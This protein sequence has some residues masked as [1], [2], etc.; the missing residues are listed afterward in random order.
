MS[1]SRLEK[2]GEQAT[3][4]MRVATRLTG[5]SADTIRKWEQR[6]AAVEPHRTDG[7]TRKFSSLDIHRLS[8]L[9]E[10]TLRGHHIMDVA[11]L[12]N[13]RLEA[14]LA[15]LD[16]ESGTAADG[17]TDADRSYARVRSDYLEAIERFDVRRAADLLSRAAMLL[18]AEDLALQVVRP[19]LL[20][21]G[22]RWHRREVSIAHEHL[23]SAQMRGLLTSVLNWSTPQ[24]G[25]PKIVV[26]TPA[27]HLHEFGTLVG[28]ILAASRGLEPIYL[29]PNLPEEEILRAVETTHAHLL[30]LSV[31]R[32]LGSDE[33]LA[34]SQSLRRM[35]SQVTTWIGVPSSDWFD[36]SGSDARL[37]ESY[38]QLD[39]AL[40]QVAAA[41]TR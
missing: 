28:A 14:L 3:Y 11:A 8:L 1:S 30:L 38:E 21:V 40:T 25:A 6:Y 33:R 24:P 18:R 7:N 23:V 17:S 19:I 35:A 2:A 4:S 34:L 27:G 41:A 29:G 12:E 26:T 9:R 10:L 39:M 16:D 31:V 32:D 37:F 22:E 15:E 5:L 13:A 20:E 36:L